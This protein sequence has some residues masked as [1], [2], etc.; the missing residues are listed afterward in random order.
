M[1]ILYT[2]KIN[3][4]SNAGFYPPSVLASS[5]FTN[6]A[7]YLANHA[8]TQ[9]HGNISILFDDMSAL[10]AFLS[11]HTLTDAALI[12]D[13]NSW[14]ST[15]GISYSSVYFTLDGTSVTGVTS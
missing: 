15:H 7:N 2:F 1:A 3:D 4:P 12:A 11:E 6:L 5:W 9:N 10:T 8:L 13:V 14:K